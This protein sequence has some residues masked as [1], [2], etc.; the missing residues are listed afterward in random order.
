M[1]VQD[2]DLEGKMTNKYFAKASHTLHLPKEVNT[3]SI[4]LASN[5]VKRRHLTGSSRLGSA[6]APK[7]G[8]LIFRVKF[9]NEIISFPL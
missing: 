5:F 3:S 9:N 2:E 6:Q 7:E 8:V 4:F 1:L